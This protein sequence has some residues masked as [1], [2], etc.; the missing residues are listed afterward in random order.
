MHAKMLSALLSA[1]FLTATLAGCQS[2]APKASTAPDTKAESKTT[3]FASTD[4]WGSVAKA[5]LKDAGKVELSIA[6]EDM[7]P[8]S[9]EPSVKDKQRVSHSQ[10]ALLNGGGYDDWALKLLDAAQPKPTLL[11]AFDISGIKCL[12]TNPNCPINEHVFYDLATVDRVA[13]QLAD[14]L[15]QSDTKHAATFVANAKAFHLEIEKLRKRTETIEEE[16]GKWNFIATEPVANYLLRLAGGNDKTPAG[17]VEQ[18]ETQAGPSVKVQAEMKSLVSRDKI[19]LL[20][21]NSQTE[22]PLALQ[23]QESAKTAGIPVLK[24]SET[25]T[26]ATD[27]VSWLHELLDRVEKTLE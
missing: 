24:V 2:P 12:A 4:V 20:V 8:H 10:V 7:N 13:S 5:V 27:Y 1:A 11:N 21:V 18:S 15:G 17:Y 16:K 9:Y 14:V 25:L 22:D 3:V 26:G 23:L 6:G 19:N